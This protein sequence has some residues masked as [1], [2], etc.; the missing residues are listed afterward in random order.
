MIARY[1]ASQADVAIFEAVKKA[2]VA[3]LAHALRWYNHIASY[4]ADAKKLPGTK[5]A[6]SEYGPAAKAAAKKAEEDEDDIDLF[7]SDD[8][9]EDAEAE[10]LKAQRLAEYHAKK[11]LSKFERL[12]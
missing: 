4:G 5:K 2:P 11:A 6:V 12:F 3:A 7:G 9:E 1:V 10:K 8:E